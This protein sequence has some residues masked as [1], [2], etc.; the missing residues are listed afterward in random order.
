[1]GS[2]IGRGAFRGEKG[3]DDSAMRRRTRVVRFYCLV[4]YLGHQ[5]LMC[6]NVHNMFL[7]FGV[8]IL[9]NMMFYLLGTTQFSSLVTSL[10][11]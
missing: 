5:I 3:T 8:S 11:K 2:R 4:F 10:Q 7:F 1:M 9:I 6:G